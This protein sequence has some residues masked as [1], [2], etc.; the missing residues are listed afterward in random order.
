VSCV[1]LLCLTLIA[2][3]ACMKSHSVCE[4]YSSP[5]LD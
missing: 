1:H 4:L 2:D 3:V 5:L